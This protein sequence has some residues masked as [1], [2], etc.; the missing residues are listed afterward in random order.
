MP[1]YSL[2]IIQKGSKSEFLLTKMEI[3]NGGNAKLK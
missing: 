2:E 1:Y 3:K